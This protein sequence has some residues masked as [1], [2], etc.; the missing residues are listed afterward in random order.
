M[1]PKRL[2][3]ARKIAG[4]S[5]EKLAQLVE[6]ESVGSRSIISNYEAGR[7]SPSF[8]FIVRV[9][10]LLDY[11]ESYFYTVD[12]EF[13]ETILQLYRNR[14]NPEFNPYYRSLAEA[15]VLADELSRCLKKATE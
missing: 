11:P 2:K 8:D 3:Q 9:A 5:Q 7:F 1:V 10:K 12:D 14:T 4:F 15:R 6:I 13:A